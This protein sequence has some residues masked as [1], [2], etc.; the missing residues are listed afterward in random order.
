MA[1]GRAR[2]PPPGS[3]DLWRIFLF[4]NA[5]K[6]ALGY[7]MVFIHLGVAFGAFGA[8]LLLP[9]LELEKNALWKILS[10]GFLF[11]LRFWGVM[12]A[13]MVL[14]APTAA[15]VEIVG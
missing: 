15:M 14:L 6:L 8:I 4:C 5:A 7:A 2:V 3:H 11:V 10:H 9:F 1:S 13:R 12:V